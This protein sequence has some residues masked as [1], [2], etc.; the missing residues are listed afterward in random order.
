MTKPRQERSG[1]IDKIT[2]HVP[3]LITQDQNELLMKPISLV[4]VEEVVFQMAS[5][6][7]PGLDGFIVSFF[8]H[9]W[10]IIKQEVWN[11][12]EYSSISRKILL[13]LNATFLTLIPK[14]EWVDSP[15]KFRPISLCNVIYKIITKVIVNRLK[16]LLPY[17]ISPEQSGFVEVR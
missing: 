17:L 5:G 7:A 14:C 6:K 8:H 15:Y 12:V 9:F 11:I 10:D 1:D 2:R 3:S 4:E 13:S 16:P